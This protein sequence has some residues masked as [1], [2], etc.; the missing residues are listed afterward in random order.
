MLWTTKNGWLKINIRPQ[1]KIKI[2][3]PAMA[4]R[5]S[6]PALIY[7]TSW[8][9]ETTL[10]PGAI[11]GREMGKLTRAK[12]LARCQKHCPLL[13]NRVGTGNQDQNQVDRFRCLASLWDLI[14]WR[15]DSGE[16]GQTWTQPGQLSF[17]EFEFG[18]RNKLETPGDS[19]HQQRLILSRRWPW[20]TVE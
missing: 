18:P 1:R 14:G 10:W 7:T 13:L 8:A 5:S 15:S 9:Q 4:Q 3:K 20:R 19:L 2:Q 16:Y 11:S 6:C 17:A 12:H